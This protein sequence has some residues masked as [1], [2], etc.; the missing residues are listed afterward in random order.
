MR[1]RV[2]DLRIAA[3]QYS[4]SN[5]RQP[6]RYDKPDLTNLL[7]FTLILDSYTTRRVHEKFG[8]NLRGARRYRSFC[9]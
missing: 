2:T 9:L 7:S 8:F 4:C 1:I 3:A 5:N 6:M